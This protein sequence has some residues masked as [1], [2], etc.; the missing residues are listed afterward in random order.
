VE[1]FLARPTKG[2]EAIKGCYPD[3]HNLEPLERKKSTCLPGLCPN[4]GAGLSSD[5]GGDGTEAAGLQFN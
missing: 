2:T 4:T 3:L 1:I 5:G